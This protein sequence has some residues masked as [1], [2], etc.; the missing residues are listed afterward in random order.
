MAKK[1]NKTSETITPPNNTSSD[2]IRDAGI[3]AKKIEK[4]AKEENIPVSEAMNRFLTKTDPLIN[5]L[6]RR[7]EFFK[8]HPEEAKI[9]KPVYFDPIPRP[10]GGLK[11]LTPSNLETS[12]G[13]VENLKKYIKFLERR[14]E[15]LHKREKEG[16]EKIVKNPKKGPRK[17][18]DEEKLKALDDWDKLD[19]RKFPINVQ[20]WLVE[21][22]GDVDGVPKVPK[23]TFYG[24]G[25]L[26]KED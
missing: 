2:I 23:S 11:L 14:L 5:G 16:I 19:K 26:R 10:S 17:Y 22:F 13:D 4:I 20:D 21:R 25:K 8:A 24:W 1:K 12:H 18:S 7:Y 3:I 15:R 6:I 9:N